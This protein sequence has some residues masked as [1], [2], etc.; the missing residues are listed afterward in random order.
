MTETLYGDWS[1]R[2]RELNWDGDQRFIIIGSI[3]SD[4]IYP[5]IPGAEITRVS[6]PEWSIMI[7]YAKSTGDTVFYPSSTKKVI[8]YTP[9]DRLAITIG[10]SNNYEVAGEG[11]AVPGSPDY[12]DTV[13]ICKSLDQSI[14]PNYPD[15]THDFTISSNRIR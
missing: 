15:I 13:I 14:N 6:G 2:C 3:S 9:D 8:S 11:W 5:A 7:E 4:G 1:I 10:A 12:I